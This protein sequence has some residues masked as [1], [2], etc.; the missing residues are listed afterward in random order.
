MRR[1]LLL[2]A[3][4]VAGCSAECPKVAEAPPPPPPQMISEAD[5]AAFI[6]KV[7]AALMAKDIAGGVA[8]YTDN[9]VLLDIS[10]PEVITTK[11]GNT[12]ATNDFMKAN[13]SKMTLNERHIQVLD[14]DT[15]V[16]TQIVT[17]DMAPAKKP[18]Q[19]IIRITDVAQKGADGNWKIVEEHLSAMPTP[20]KAK[21]PVVKEWTPPAAAPAAPAAPGGAKPADA[22]PATPA[23]ATPAKPATPSKPN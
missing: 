11:E 18:I 10:A 23:P 1:S 3:L 15:F 4:F 2:S 8:L 9:A 22:K 20:P 12:A 17:A 6:D 5:A 19:Q 14:A 16:S 7:P 13:V 21:L